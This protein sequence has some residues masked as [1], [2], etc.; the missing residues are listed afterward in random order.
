MIVLLKKFF[1]PG[2]ENCLTQDYDDFADYVDFVFW[3]F[4]WIKGDLRNS[5]RFNLNYLKF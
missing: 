5:I 3:I 1:L 4:L 2:R